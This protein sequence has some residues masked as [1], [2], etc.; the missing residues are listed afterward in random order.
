MEEKIDKPLKYCLY[1]RKST[2]SDEKQ[3]ASI[4]SQVKEMSE[5]AQKNKLDVVDIKRESHSAKAVGQRPVFNE[6]IEHLRLGKFNA[7]LTWA[8]DR[9]SRNAGDLGLLVDLL[10]QKLLIEIQT[11]SQR[12]TDNPNEKFLLMILGAQGK[13][14]NDQKGLNV[15]RGMR[16][17]CEMGL[18]PAP[19]P[20]GYLNH[21]DRSK[22]CHVIVDTKRAPIVI[23][24]FEKVGEYGW[25]GRK[26]HEWLREI[27][28]KGPNGK[29]FALANIYR[30][31]R[32]DFYYGRFQYPKDG[33]KWYQG[34]HVPLITQ[35]LFEKVQKQLDLQT[36]RERVSKEFAFTRL[37]LCGSC[38]SG[39]TAQEKFKHQQNGN[40]HRYV[41]YGCTKAR[42]KNCREKYLREDELIKQLSDLV[43]KIDLSKSGIKLKISSELERFTHFQD[44]LGQTLHI[45]SNDINVKKYTR[46]ILESGRLEEK[47]EIMESFKSRLSITQRQVALLEH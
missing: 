25:S 24:I 41:Y 34:I 7:I 44:M 39:I 4:E 43:D 8:P 11:Y 2:E 18:W 3:A 12:F 16:A 42:D 1:A 23:E 36:S 9:L 26:A 28:F 47:R 37:M 14:E 35:D 17:K 30:L 40:T 6:M 20:T 29:S 21:P 45:R 22:K 32:Q 15:K 46:Y 27:N 33:G 10:D 38:G 13:L 19:A 5:I 31:L